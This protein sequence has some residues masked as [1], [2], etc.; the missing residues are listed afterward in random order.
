MMTY[1]TKI[2]KMKGRNKLEVTTSYFHWYGIVGSTEGTNNRVMYE[3]SE[4][5]LLFCITM[6]FQK[7]L[8]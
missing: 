6:W 5:I 3:M 8:K 7:Q 2:I 4:N 1:R